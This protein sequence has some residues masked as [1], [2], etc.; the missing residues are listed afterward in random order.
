MAAGQ[1][2][3]RRYR[4]VVPGKSHLGA[5]VYVVRF[6]SDVVK[7]GWTANPVK[8]MPLHDRAAQTH[9]GKVE[10]AWFSAPHAGARA[11]EKLLIKHC[12]TRATSTAGAEYFTGVSFGDVVAF[13]RSLRFDPITESERQRADEERRN[14]TPVFGHATAAVEPV[15]EPWW[16][17]EDG[18][19]HLER[20]LRMPR[21]DVE[22]IVEPDREQVEQV[23]GAYL[24]A[25]HG[26]AAL[27]AEL[28][29][30]K[31]RA[32]EHRES[33]VK[34]CNYLYI[35]YEVC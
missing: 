28:A 18:I 22:R 20:L 7:V 17:T 34:L 35:R 4:P 11:N 21:E 12:S 24:E 9:G 1:P 2:T 33:R 30:A 23:I 5:Y 10:E 8:R 29:A 27:E 25:E 31:K 26:V 13:A 14:R 19:D 16:W 6:T 3:R 32:R 15:R